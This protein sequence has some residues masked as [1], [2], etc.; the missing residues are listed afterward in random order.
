MAPR[1]LKRQTSG[2]GLAPAWVGLFIFLLGIGLYWNTL[3]HGFVF[4]DEALIT[5]NRQVHELLWGD[6]FSRSGYRPLRTFT[7]AVNY[8]LGGEDPFGYHLFN[9]V[10][11]ALNA[12]LVWGLLHLWTGSSIVGTAGAVLFATH[13]VQTAAV[14][15]VSGRKD[16]LATFF[17]LLGLQVFTYYR[18]GAGR[19]WLLGCWILFALAILS[20]EVAIVFPLLLILAE[21]ALLDQGDSSSQS[22]LS[23]WKARLRRSYGIYAAA[24]TLA[25]LGLYHAIFIVKA[26]RMVEFWGGSLWS[27]L[28]T[29]FKLFVHYLKLVFWPYP[30][31][32][33]YKGGV[34]SLSTGLLEPATLMS[35]LILVCFAATALWIRRRQPLVSLAMFWFLATLLPVLQLIPFH[36]IAADHFLYLP[37]VGVALAGGL[38]ARVGWTRPKMKKVALAVFLIL[39]AL[40][41]MTTVVRNRDWKNSQSLWE[42]TY[43]AA[44]NSYRA[45]TNLGRIY[46]QSSN[47]SLRQKGVEMTRVA[48]K[49]SPEDPVA[50]AN[51][52]SMLYIMG[53]TRLEQEQLDEASQLTWQAIE[54]LERA[55]EKRTQRRIG[56]EQSGKRLPATGD[57]LDS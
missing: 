19:K 8:A 37:M 48:L 40:S 39:V 2:K 45:N 4:D 50:R 38:L 15:Y 53:R 11:H 7:Y 49:L 31:I 30:L 29:T 54:H 47:P 3:G 42:A 56:V 43:A 22:L 10:L 21:W 20:K 18:R 5:Q 35:F 27:N 34:F 1:K 32:V 26:T 44:P 16:L 23:A 36:E 9:I 12:V 25:A 24:L 28:G 55:L 33:D 13:P 6:I 46:F 41:V 52:G 17:V 14:A 51:L 57:D